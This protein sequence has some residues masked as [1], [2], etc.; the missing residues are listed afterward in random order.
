[1][2]MGDGAYKVNR[3]GQCSCMR[4]EALVATFWAAATL[5]CHTELLSGIIGL[6]SSLDKGGGRVR[7]K[8]HWR[9]KQ[10]FAENSQQLIV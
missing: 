7:R 8:R 5:H 2:N 3:A 9:G 4:K 6:A 10:H 1:M